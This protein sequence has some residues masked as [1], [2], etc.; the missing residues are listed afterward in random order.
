MDNDHARRV[1]FLRGEPMVYCVICNV[2]PYSPE[3]HV[4]T[5]V[6]TLALAYLGRVPWPTDCTLRRVIFCADGRQ[7][8]VWFPEG[9]KEDF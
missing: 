8:A 7:R 5:D 1:S 4:H 6:H 9:L 3:L 2:L